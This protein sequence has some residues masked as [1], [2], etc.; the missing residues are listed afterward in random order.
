M[1]EPATNPTPETAPKMPG[2]PILPMNIPAMPTRSGGGPMSVRKPFVSKFS[3]NPQEVAVRKV[4]D[5]A[6]KVINDTLGNLKSA[7]DKITAQLETLSEDQRKIWEG[8]TGLATVGE[9][10]AVATDMSA[11]AAKYSA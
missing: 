10:Q 9:L 8:L 1:K 5:G 4:H 7:A 11:L 3:T 6:A 2:S